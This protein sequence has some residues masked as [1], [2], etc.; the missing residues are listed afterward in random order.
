MNEIKSLG[1]QKLAIVV[2]MG[3]LGVPSP[4]LTLLL[5]LVIVVVVVVVVVL[6]QE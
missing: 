2:A 1:L 6:I 3:F 4:S 5:V